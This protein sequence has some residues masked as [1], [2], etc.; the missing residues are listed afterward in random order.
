MTKQTDK[1]VICTDGGSRGNPGPSAAGFVL[2]DVAGNQLSARGIY[3]GEGTNNTAEYTG[4]L[5]ALEAAKELGTKAVEIF[6]DSELVVRQINGEYKV[7]SDN[8]R[9]LFKQV[10]DVLEE[11]KSWKITY[12]PRENNDKADKLVNQALDLQKNVQAKPIKNK[13]SGKTIR[14]G[15][16]I[17]G[18][19]TTL[20]NILK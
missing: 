13:V 4:V 11:F 8:I 10:I 18:G 1:I 3:L 9:P 14:L 19:G 20:I 7:K 17:S 15:V 5:K 6:S 2:T 12:I 16:L